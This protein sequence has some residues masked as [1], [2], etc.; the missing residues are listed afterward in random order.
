MNVSASSLRAGTRALTPLHE[1]P[2]MHVDSGTDDRPINSCLI[3]QDIPLRSQK[4]P[5]HYTV[6]F[7]NLEHSSSAR[8]VE[9]HVIRGQSSRQNDLTPVENEIGCRRRDVDNKHV[10]GAANQRDVCLR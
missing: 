8:E 10:T 2:A 7:V 3:N 6:R 5:I 4:C 1:S 9:N